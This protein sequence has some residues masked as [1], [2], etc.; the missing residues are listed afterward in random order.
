MSAETKIEW[1]HHTFNS[2]WGCQRVSPGCGGAK[3]EG[4]CYAEAFAHRLGLDIWGPQAP[5]RFFGDAHWREPVRWNDRAARNGIRERVFLNSMADTFEDRR[6]LDPIRERI[7]LLIEATPWLDW[8]VLTKRPQNIERLAPRWRGGWPL[9]AWA[10]T[11]CEDQQ[12]ADERIPHL[13]ATPAAV[14]FLSCEPLLGPVDF[15]AWF[16]RYRCSGCVGDPDTGPDCPG[17]DGLPWQWTIVGGESGP[18][19]RP[20]SED[21]V[22]SIRDQCTAAGVSFFLKQKLDGRRKVSLP[23]LDGRQWAEFPA[24]SR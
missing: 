18:G 21:W 16:E 10:G 14:K 3:G 23:M 11:T 9:N 24:V 12:R 4:G 7:Y 6:D 15:D 20:M 13:L 19:A 1:A 2:H 22:R 5:R 17:H 8:L